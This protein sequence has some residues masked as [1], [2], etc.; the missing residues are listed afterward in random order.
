MNKSV[1]LLMTIFLVACGAE[2][3]GH[4]TAP[5]S[6]PAQATSSPSV[7]SEA[8]TAF[9]KSFREG[10]VK[11]GITSCIKSAN[12]G[13]KARKP[14]EC[15]VNQLNESLSDDEVLAMS[16]G[17]EPADWTQ[18]MEKITMGCMDSLKK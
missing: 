14:C 4:Q 8:Q 7:L 15:T 13:E 18:R 10:F 9:I 2:S 11:E 17:K 3:S 6:A 16:T 5:A 1:I 12:L